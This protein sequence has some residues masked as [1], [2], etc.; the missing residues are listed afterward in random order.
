[1]NI[2]KNIRKSSILILGLLI[3]IGCNRLQKTPLEEL[4]QIGADLKKIKTKEYS[5]LIKTYRSY[6][7]DTTKNS[8]II[9]FENN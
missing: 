3:F 9:F 4:K 5:Y 1:M 8:G 7:G 2:I 6:S